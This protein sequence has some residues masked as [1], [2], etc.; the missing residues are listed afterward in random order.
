MAGVEVP[1]EAASILVVVGILSFSTA[2][3]VAAV[4][5]AVVHP[6]SD[7]DRIATEAAAEQANAALAQPWRSPA[8][9]LADNSACRRQAYKPFI[10][11]QIS[12][13]LPPMAGDCPLLQ[14]PNLS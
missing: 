3:D 5:G 13:C 11:R 4:R 1:L 10:P 7:G 12:C 6:F 9:P 8:R 2:V 14:P